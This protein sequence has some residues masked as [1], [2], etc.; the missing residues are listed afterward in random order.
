MTFL[1]S[2]G[3][4]GRRHRQWRVDPRGTWRRPRRVQ[5]TK[6]VHAVTQW[7]KQCHDRWSKQIGE[8]DLI[9]LSLVLVYKFEKGHFVN[10]LGQYRE[11][12]CGTETTLNGGENSGGGYEMICEF[13]K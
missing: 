12:S 3:S 8:V 10:C 4:S 9:L 2:I 11:G 13:S 5:D 1:R 7:D 6:P